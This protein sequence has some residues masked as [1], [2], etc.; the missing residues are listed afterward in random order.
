MEGSGNH[1]S[2]ERGSNG[3]GRCGNDKDGDSDEDDDSSSSSESS[4]SL[5]YG[6]QTD[7][8]LEEF[9]AKWRLELAGKVQN[10]RDD[11]THQED[12]VA[13]RAADLYEA[14]I[15]AEK[16][17][18]MHEAINLY[19]RAVRLDPDIECKVTTSLQTKNH[20]AYSP[21]PLPSPDGDG[22]DNLLLQECH[23]GGVEEDEPDLMIRFQRAF[24][25]DG[26][27][28]LCEPLHDNPTGT[29]W[30]RGYTTW[31]EMFIEEPRPHFHGCYIS[32]TSY[33][34]HGENSFQ[35]QFYRP[36]HLVHYFR[37]LRFFPEGAVLMLTTPDD[38]L[39]SLPNLR[40]R[41]ARPPVLVGRYKLVGGNRLVVV[42]QRKEEPT[43]IGRYKRS[44]KTP[45]ETKE[46]IYHADLEIQ[47]YKEKLHFQLMWIRYSIC[48][49]RGN[50]QEMEN[51]FDLSPTNFPP[52]WFSRVK[53]YSSSTTSSLE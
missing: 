27:Q 46:L 35:D 26:I 38:P 31:R 50:Q 25:R 15:E 29:L 37:Y 40:S 7:N 36:W 10:K 30:Q 11:G 45:S 5:A 52:F 44:R 48:I 21:D 49:R 3:E 4:S 16:N 24:T 19:R 8:F 28:C 32:K 23:I 47:N 42:L 6:H 12:S 34:R 41:K 33:V 13:A 2:V 43:I 53:S 20:G 1:G 17:G 18:D 9:R 22:S 14:G 51:D 39:Q